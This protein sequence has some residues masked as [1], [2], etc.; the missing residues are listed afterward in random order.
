MPGR[1]GIFSSL[2]LSFAFFCSFLSFFL[3]VFLVFIEANRYLM[4]L[5]VF[6]CEGIQVG[7]GCVTCKYGRERRARGMK[8]NERGSK[9][10]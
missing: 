5:Y 9:K 4:Y 8:K 6:G 3:L 2:A 10:I 7:H 1:R